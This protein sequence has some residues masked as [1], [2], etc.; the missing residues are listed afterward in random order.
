MST[1]SL[2]ALF[3]CLLLYFLCRLT[4]P[5]PVFSFLFWPLLLLINLES[6]LANLESYEDSPVKIFVMI[7]NATL[8]IIGYFQTSLSIASAIAG[9]IP[10]VNAVTAFHVSAIVFLLALA[11]FVMWLRERAKEEKLII[12]RI[13]F[14]DGTITLTEKENPA[15]ELKKWKGLYD[16][17]AI[18]EEMYNRKRDELMK[19]K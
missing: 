7:A 14:F 19:K 12:Q 11:V 18:T 1:V 16:E 6:L 4:L 13:A 9:S 17:G 3:L 5:A 10:N 15:D 2:I 8:I